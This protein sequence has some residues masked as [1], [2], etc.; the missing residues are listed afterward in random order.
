MTPYPVRGE[1]G[2]LLVDAMIAATAITNDLAV[3][4]RIHV[5]LRDSAFHWLIRSN[6]R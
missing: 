6:S 3:V 5:T 4:T 2:D 1:S